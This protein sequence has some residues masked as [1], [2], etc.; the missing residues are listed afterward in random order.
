[1]MRRVV[2]CFAALGASVASAEPRDTW[3]LAATLH[4]DVLLLATPTTTAGGA[5]G[6]IGIELALRDRYLA[7]IDLG[8]LWMVG[9]PVTT[10]L[11][12]G[13]QRRGAWSPAAWLAC[14]ML[15][16]DRVEVISAASQRRRDPLW[17]IGVRISPLRFRSAWGTVSALE[18]G[19]GTDLSGTL[20]DLTVL[21]T[22]ATW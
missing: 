1:M 11:A 15:W 18:L 20:L 2:I 10:R 14:D 22:S 9:N 19:V 16:S 5:G 3:T 6:G 7:Q 12:L 8:A 17:A 21:R 13:G 4:Q